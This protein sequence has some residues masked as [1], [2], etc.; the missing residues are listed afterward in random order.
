MY[1]SPV[2]LDDEAATSA[3]ATSDITAAAAQVPLHQQHVREPC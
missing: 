1:L 2:D 3:A